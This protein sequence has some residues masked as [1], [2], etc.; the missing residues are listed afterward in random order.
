MDGGVVGGVHN[1]GWMAIDGYM[2]EGWRECQ[3]SLSEA[4][5]RKKLTSIKTMKLHIIEHSTQYEENWQ[6]EKYKDMYNKI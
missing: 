3:C 1:T 4:W 6:K 2:I 5:K